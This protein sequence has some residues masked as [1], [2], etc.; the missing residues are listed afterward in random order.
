MVPR[1]WRRR[2]STAA[3]RPRHRLPEPTAAR[4]AVPGGFP[5][6]PPYE[7]DRD[8]AVPDRRRARAA[9]VRP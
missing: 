3:P 4:A 1:S 6:R 9:Q 2:L 8:G 5:D 7:K